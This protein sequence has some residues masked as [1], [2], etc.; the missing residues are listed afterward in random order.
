MSNFW[1]DCV[2]FVK[3]GPTVIITI[4]HFRFKIFAYI[5]CITKCGFMNIFYIHIHKCTGPTLY[6]HV[7][8]FIT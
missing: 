5:T 1:Q 4:L 8:R 3:L 6:M 2:K 7:Q